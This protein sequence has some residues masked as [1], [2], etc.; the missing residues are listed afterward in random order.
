MTTR[1]VWLLMLWGCSFE[2]VL[3]PHEHGVSVCGST[4]CEDPT[5]PTATGTTTTSSEGGGATGGTT[6][7]GDDPTPSTD[8]CAPDGCDDTG[9][10][11]GAD[12]GCDHP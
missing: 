7:T 11:T 5:P 12:T 1:L 10:E 6:T 8:P 2:V 3:D 9:A 4:P